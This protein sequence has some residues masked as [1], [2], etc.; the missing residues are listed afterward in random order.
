MEWD[1][2]TAR[3]LRVAWSYVFILRN[4]EEKNDFWT[5]ES[6]NCFYKVILHTAV[7]FFQVI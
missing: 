5:H 4:K 7:T 3:D 6:H 2:E 1:S